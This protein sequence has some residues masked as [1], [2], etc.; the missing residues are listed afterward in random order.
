MTNIVTRSATFLPSTILFKRLVVVTTTM[1]ADKTLFAAPA[2]TR[3]L[4]DLIG[5]VRNELVANRTAVCPS[6]QG[7]MRPMHGRSREVVTG[8]RCR[9]CGATLS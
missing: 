7:A 1:F 8:G 2:K 3:T 4:D 5:D 6:C 9:N